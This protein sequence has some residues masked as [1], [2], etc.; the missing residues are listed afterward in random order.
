[1][2]PLLDK[3][4]DDESPAGLGYVDRI[5]PGAVGFVHDAVVQ[6]VI[7]LRPAL[8]VVTDDSAMRVTV[9]EREPRSAIDIDVVRAP[10]LPEAVVIELRVF[11]QHGP[12]AAE[13]SVLVVVE[14]AVAH[15]ET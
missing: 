11:D 2:R 15:R 14:V 13:N 9:S 5:A 8:D 10:D 6:N 7:F 4:S 12:G 1:M 3:I